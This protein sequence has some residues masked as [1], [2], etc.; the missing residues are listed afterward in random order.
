MMKRK[1]EYSYDEKC[2]ELAARFLQ[3]ED[4]SVDAHHKAVQELA[5]EIQNTIETWIKYDMEK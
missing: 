4:L 1:Q 5:Q 2:E 3:D